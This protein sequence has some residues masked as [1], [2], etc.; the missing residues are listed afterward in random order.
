MW[1]RSGGGE[2]TAEARRAQRGGDGKGGPARYPGGQDAFVG[3]AG[4]RSAL[5]TPHLGLVQDARLGGIRE[6][7]EDPPPS[8][9]P[10]PL[11]DVG[12]CAG[13]DG[14]WRLLTVDVG[15][16]REAKGMEVGGAG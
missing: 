15:E 10:P 14:G 8:I 1:R 9:L 13:L 5:P 2:G 16:A 4:R 12:P 3:R 6:G 11:T 7:R